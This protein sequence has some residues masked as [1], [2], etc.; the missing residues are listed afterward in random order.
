MT[1]DVLVGDCRDVMAAMDAAIA[2]ARIAH[3]GRQI[4]LEIPR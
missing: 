4:P 3:W 2:E 1:W